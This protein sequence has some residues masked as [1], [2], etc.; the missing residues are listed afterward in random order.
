MIAD[1]T[2]PRKEKIRG[3]RISNLLE[4]ALDVMQSEPS[5]LMSK[6]HIS[7][8]AGKTVKVVANTAKGEAF[9][10][11]LQN[12]DEALT[13]KN[14]GTLLTMPTNGNLF[15]NGKNREADGK[16]LVLLTSA[17]GTWKKEVSNNLSYINSVMRLD[18]A[19]VGKDVEEALLLKPT[20]KGIYGSIRNGFKAEEGKT[21][22][23]IAMGLNPIQVK[24]VMQDMFLDTARMLAFAKDGYLLFKQIQSASFPKVGKALTMEA[25]DAAKRD[26][27]AAEHA[28]EKVYTA[29]GERNTRAPKALNEDR[30]EWSLEN[31]LRYFNTS[32]VLETNP[33]LKI[34]HEKLLVQVNPYVVNGTYFDNITLVGVSD[35]SE[36]KQVTDA[37][38][39]LDSSNDPDIFDFVGSIQAYEAQRSRYQTSLGRM[40]KILPSRVQVALGSQVGADGILDIFSSEEH[41]WDIMMNTAHNPNLPFLTAKN[42]GEAIVKAENKNQGISYRTVDGHVLIPVSENEEGVEYAAFKS[43]NVDGK[44]R[45]Q[46]F[47]GKPIDPVSGAI[48]KPAETEDASNTGYESRLGWYKP[49]LDVETKVRML[50]D[51]FRKSGVAVKVVLDSQLPSNG[52]VKIDKG[53]AT[54][55]IHPDKLQG[56]TIA[57]EFGH[58]LLEALGYQNELVQQAIGEL[59]GTE[60]WEKVRETYPDLNERDLAMEV[61]TTWIGRRGSEMVTNDKGKVSKLRTLY[62]RIMRAIGKLIGIKP[63]ATE[64]LAQEL[65]FGEGEL[66]LDE[67]LETYQEQRGTQTASDIIKTTGRNLKDRMNYIRQTQGTSVEAQEALAEARARYQ[68]A[69]G[70]VV[71]DRLKSIA[72]MSDDTVSAAA[73]AANALDAISAGM[74][75]GRTLKEVEVVALRRADQTLN[76]VETLLNS[77]ENMETIKKAPEEMTEQEVAFQGLADKIDFLREAKNNLTSAVSEALSNKLKANSTNSKLLSELGDGNMFALASNPQLRDLMTDVDSV[78]KGALGVKEFKNPIVQ[79]ISKLVADALETARLDAKQD[80]A[81]VAK[82]LDDFTAAGGRLEDIVDM[83]TGAFKGEYSADYYRLR[84][85]AEKESLKPG[86]DKMALLRFDAANTIQEF[87]SEYYQNWVIN[88]SRIQTLRDKIRRDE[89]L[90]KAGFKRSEIN[91]RLTANRKEFA[92]LMQPSASDFMKYHTVEVAEG[93]DAAYQE[94]FKKTEAAKAA[95]KETGERAKADVFALRNFIVEHVVINVNGKNIPTRGKFSTVKVKE[96]YK[97]EEYSTKPKPNSKYANGNWATNPH[98]DVINGLKE[99]MGN[100]AG[101]PGESFVEQGFLPLNFSSQA[102]LSTKEKL[103][104]AGQKLKGA[105]AD[106]ASASLGQTAKMFGNEVELDSRGNRIYVRA[107]GLFSQPTDEQ[108]KSLQGMTLE[109]VGR[110]IKQFVK[111]GHQESAKR[112]LEPVAYLTR[113]VFEG[114]EIIDGKH[115]LKP[116]KKG[117]RMREATKLAKGTNIANALDQWFEG[118]LGDKWEDPT[119]MDA[120]AGQIQKYT[121]LMGVGLN[122]PAWIN[123]YAYGSLQRHLEFKGRDH[124]SKENSRKGHKMISGNFATI[125]RDLVKDHGGKF[126]NKVSALVHTLDVADD[127]R[128][129]P[130]NQKESLGNKLISKAFIGQTMGEIA[131]QN[132]VLFAMMLEAKVTLAD[133]SV[134]NLYDAYQLEDGVLKLPSGATVETTQGDTV[135]LNTEFVARF[136][137]KVKSIN[138]YIHGAYNKQDAGTWQRHWVG[139]LGMQFRRWLPMGIKKRFGERM[140][141]ESRE[142]EEIGE[143]RAL[144]EVTKAMLADVQKGKNLKEALAALKETDPV[145]YQAAM[146]ALR[147]VAISAGL[148]FLLAGLY[149]FGFDEEDEFGFLGALAINRTERLAQEMMT[150]T[151]MGL[152]NLFNETSASPLASWGKLKTAGEF[153]MYGGQ[154]AMSIIGFADPALYTSG[155]RKGESKT[156][157]RLEAM[158]PVL[159]HRRRFVEMEQ[160]HKQYS[161]LWNFIHS[162]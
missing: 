97:N 68:S 112:A 96:Q 108:I 110:R 15:T 86:G 146:K 119:A 105:A 87:S 45:A 122:I 155:G 95:A 64:Q 131:M 120:L 22:H 59:K 73:E 106:A 71:I 27:A 157:R 18:A 81:K 98:K 137:N 101:A 70:G 40:T 115:V 66:S 117:D 77:L 151:P 136:R 78:T 69:T 118:V 21:E 33:D 2:M 145:A 38:E 134:T 83:E 61:L 143:Y 141:N 123:N 5:R 57:H 65:M 149:A 13:V 48:G 26:V 138:H 8:S 24:G 74:R 114:S 103:Q 35:D 116:G 44:N 25:Y 16:S 85:E 28:Y 60:L 12:T 1:G 55:Y 161:M 76:D 102:Q 31:W 20:D 126:D 132:Q 162:K 140:Y 50:Q 158:L 46:K 62:N 99:A 154:D 72:N 10:Q 9:L 51:R 109:D 142:R 47:S 160:N 113:E 128:E 6:G 41:L 94:A 14:N 4:F 53:T 56:D 89:G 153:V 124:F 52:A 84:K 152:V 130:F 36:L 107:T 111:D 32:D 23:M 127:Q 42:L 80:E 43:P 121:S 19:N 135:E 147:E 67:K 125:M 39:R 63:K 139:R 159:G 82:I 148:F 3:E 7:I 30:S 17:I 100:A 150:Y 144:V 79:S 88:S 37:M 75:T 49:E 54:V 58:I 29:M 156:W 11:K 92:D 133:G 129:L 90:I 104:R 93:F 91:E 34:V